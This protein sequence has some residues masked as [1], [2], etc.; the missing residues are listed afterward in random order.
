MGCGGG[1]VSYAV[2]PYVRQEIAFDLARE[3]LDVVSNEATRRNLRN[4]EIILGDIK[5]LP[6]SDESFDY[7]PSRF[8]AHHWFELNSGLKEAC[9]VLKPNGKA[10]FIDVISPALPKLDTP[11]QAIEI[12]RDISH[13]RDYSVREWHEELEFNGLHM[14]K[15]SMLR[16]RL[17]FSSWIQRMNTPE[18]RVCAI[19]DL[20]KLA[21]KAVKHYF[22][23]EYDHSFTV[24][25]SVFEL[26]KK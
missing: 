12:L 2:S 19:L 5:A 8:S 20:Q 10:V 6:F 25:V 18:N 23:I 3:M 4:I 11:L 13:V 17:D 14:L 9:R 7:V 21:P 22:E 16:L 15:Q 26:I 1:H 24:D